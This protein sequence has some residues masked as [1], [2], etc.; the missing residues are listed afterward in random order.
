MRK[1]V[2]KSHEF[3]IQ[4]YGST[5]TGL[6]MP[7]SDVDIGVGFSR[8]SGSQQQTADVEPQAP[9]DSIHFYDPEYSKQKNNTHPGVPNRL[10]D[11]YKDLKW[12]GSQKFSRVVY[13]G[14][15]VPIVTAVHTKS[16]IAVQVLEKKK[17]GGQD[18]CVKE[19]INN[20]PN[21]AQLFPVVRTMLNMRGLLNPFGGGISSYGAFMMLAASLRH[22][23]KHQ[24]PQQP[25]SAQLLHFLD[26]WATFNT[27][28]FGIDVGR[29]KD[30]AK[31]FK[32]SSFELVKDLPN[33]VN[34]GHVDQAL[35]KGDFTRAG[36]HRI[37]VTKPRQPY[38][39]C[40]QDP[41]NPWNDLGRGCHAIKH[42]QATCRSLRN[43]LQSAMREHDLKRDPAKHANPFGFSAADYMPKRDASLLLPLVGRCHEVYAERRKRMSWFNFGNKV[44]P[45]HT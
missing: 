30:P 8:D 13:R 41:A 45:V 26:F 24:S 39:M 27:A 21:L 43:D 38:L 11:F 7:S 4:S 18:A 16:G 10:E 12:R 32:K 40:L 17:P 28:R 31:S 33:F 20:Y 44:R 5:A 37:G 15:P 22:K 9:N 25:L 29:N 19:H 34:N 1:N 3:Y 2:Y 23:N 14:A 35:S 36:Q 6:A 42:I